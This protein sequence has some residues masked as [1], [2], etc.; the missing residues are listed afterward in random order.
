MRYVRPRSMLFVSLAPLLIGTTGVLAEV[1]SAQQIEAD[2]VLQHQLRTLETPITPERDAA[3]A[4]DGIKNGKWGF[5]TEHEPQPWWRVDLGATFDLAYLLVYNRTE[6]ASRA[7]RVIVLA[8][9]DGKELE[10][11]YQHDGATFF[12]H[13]DGKPLKIGL[14]DV[15]ARFVRLQLPGTTYFHLD[16]VEVYAVG[17]GRNIAL[18]KPCTQSSASQWSTR[19]IL[20]DAA[21]LPLKTTFFPAMGL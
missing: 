18:H 2:W 14:A 12:G 17:D 21:I 10:P 7:A 3:G 20:N 1:I 8:S 13:P 19:S 9:K 6:F 16:E 15:S 4:C 11:V 5:H